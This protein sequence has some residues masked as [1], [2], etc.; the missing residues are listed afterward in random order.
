MTA[1][2]I[3]LRPGEKL[4]LNGA[5]IKVDRRVSFDILNNVA[6]LLE[7]HV[8]QAAEANTP[9]KQLYFVVQSALMDPSDIER[10]SGLID[11]MLKNT[12]R[13]FSNRQV[14]CSLQDIEGLVIRRKYFEALRII[15]SLYVIEDEIIRSGNRLGSQAA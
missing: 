6:F 4:Y 15:R 2:R 13:N 5:V 3:R 12:I 14:V 11:S 1:M 7:S 9:L 8:L 10:V